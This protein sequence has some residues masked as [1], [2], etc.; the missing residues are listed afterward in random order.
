M[1]N[2]FSTLLILIYILQSLAPLFS[3]DMT[4]GFSLDNKTK[5][6]IGLNSNYL[7]RGG[8]YYVFDL[9]PLLIGAPMY[10]EHKE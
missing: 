10:I 7:S 9:L 6:V 3:N 5:V 2:N 8:P 4:L 1:Y